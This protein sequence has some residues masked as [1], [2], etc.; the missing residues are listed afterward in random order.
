MGFGIRRAS[1]R[2]AYPSRALTLIAPFS[3]G[4]NVGITARLLQPY[5]ERTLG[6]SIA[7]SFI[8]GAGGLAGHLLAAEAA[9][10]G[11]TLTLVSASLTT[12]PWLNRAPTAKPNDFA[13][14]GQVTALPSVLLVR[15][16]SPHENLADIVAALRAAPE[17]ATTGTM[18]GWWPPALALTPFTT[19]AAIK[20]C[21]VSTYYSGAELV[22]ALSQGQL[23]L[24]VVGLADVGPSLAGGG[25]RALAVSGRTPAL[26][27]ARSFREQGWNV[28]TAWWRGLAA[29][30]ET[31]AEVIGLLDATSRQ[32][33]DSEALRV[34]FGRSGLPVDPL[35][36][37][38]FGK[39]VLDEYQTIGGLFSLLGLNVRASQ[40]A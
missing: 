19:Q 40:P 33:L 15:A 28:T 10:D 2:A 11:Y 22:V 6:Q 4:S 38:A 32:A 26:P 13:F 7:L 5:L 29:P 36:A 20:P 39:F 14:I 1:A 12:Q 9:P 16:D 35:D 8:Q 27:A 18:V 21:V 24:V 34:E 37:A 31:P 25:L 3:P 30:A 17:S 23:D